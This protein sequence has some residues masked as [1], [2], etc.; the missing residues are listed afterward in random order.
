[1]AAKKTT[2]RKSA[3]RKTAAATRTGRPSGYKEEYN[4]IAR[5][6]CLL[7]ATDK[8]LAEA[9]GISE[10]TLNNWKAKHPDFMQAIK[11]GRTLPDGEVAL[12]LYKRAN[13]AEWVEQ[14]AVKVKRVEYEDGKR[15]SEREEVVVVD[16]IRRAPPDTV[17]GIFWLKNR[18]PDTWRDRHELVV[19]EESGLAA[20]LQEARK[21]ARQLRAQL[22]K[23]E[24]E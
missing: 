17:A 23:E 21:R 20:Q 6:L 7:G 19:D 3:G 18:K 24:G 4:R 22:E 9:L 2:A 5:N 14:Q 15:V 11:H 13:G 16:V 8:E 12:S 10:R 1:M